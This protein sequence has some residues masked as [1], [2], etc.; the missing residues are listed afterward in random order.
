MNQGSLCLVLLYSFPFSLFFFV[1]FLFSFY[2]FLVGLFML[3]VQGLLSIGIAFG[4]CSCWSLYLSTWAFDL[5]YLT[6]PVLFLSNNQVCLLE[7]VSL[8]LTLL[9]VSLCWYLS[10]LCFLSAA[11][12]PLCMFSS[13]P[14]ICLHALVLPISM[15]AFVCGLIFPCRL[16]S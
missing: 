16:I 11:N 2:Q 15:F 4:F 6:S 5:V 8:F 13:G 12:T 7:C 1:F 10:H 9:W 14:N 3:I